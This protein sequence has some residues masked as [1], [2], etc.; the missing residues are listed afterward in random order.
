MRGDRF[1]IEYNKWL[2]QVDVSDSDSVWQEVED[3]LDY[4]ETWNN[5]STRLDEV[6]PL[7]GIINTMKYA[8]I[9]AAVTASILLMVLPL[10]DSGE[11]SVQQTIISDQQSEA[12]Q[13]ESSVS[14]GML[15]VTTEK[16]A[17]NVTMADIETTVKADAG[18]IV[19]ADAETIVK[20]DAETIVKADAETI[21]KAD[22]ET[23]V[24]A[25]AETIVKADAK[26]I[27]KADAENIVKADAKTIV[28]ADAETIV[29]ADAGT[30]VRADAENIVL[31]TKKPI[32]DK[33]IIPPF[34][35]NNLLASNTTIIQ[36]AIRQQSPIE[37]QNISS[38]GSG[39]ASGPSF[40]IVEAGLVYG[41]KNTWLLNSETINGLK[42]GKL[43]NTL[44]TFIQ[45]LG[46][47][48]TL[49]VNNKH[50]LGIEFLWKSR[51]GQHYQQYIN[52]NFIDRSIELS[53]LKLQAF[54]LLGRDGAPGQIL[55]GGY[56]GKLTL[57]EE[58]QEKTTFSITSNY[59]DLDYGI[60][61]GG[62]Y[63]F[64]ISNRI[65]VKP[66]LRASYNLVNIFGGD[67]LIPSHL[68]KTKNLVAS[69]N[70]S[71][72]YRFLN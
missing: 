69:V 21:V 35:A 50:L 62:Q 59:R 28:R 1:D 55:V 14:D 34:T 63:N 37:L 6:M 56:F 15:Q 60:L 49:E 19:K 43:G 30:I 26:T 24:K 3:E 4:I 61:A 66:G 58:K 48:A 68:K 29:K 44:P 72:S 12:L 47:S 40:R 70:I 67:D 42:P 20:A 27:V 39:M 11:R 57:A 8:K 7:Q 18:T 54:Y 52:A 16:E 45:D 5:I 38:S 23:I 22:A 46:I 2:Q 36:G 25:D 33:I 65:T 53:Y 71:I 13:T 9:V 10:K 31:T 17:I 32:F 51:V 64:T 41:F